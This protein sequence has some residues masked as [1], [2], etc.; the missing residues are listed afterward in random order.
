MHA[1]WHQHLKGASYF[2]AYG[3]CC[4]QHSR[5]K[6]VLTF[7]EKKSEHL[8][9]PGCEFLL[10]FVDALVKDFYEKHFECL[11]LSLHK[12]ENASKILPCF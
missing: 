7:P 3:L 9:K 6:N 1:H 12:I 4:V 11:S 10:C 2:E 8:Y 5:M